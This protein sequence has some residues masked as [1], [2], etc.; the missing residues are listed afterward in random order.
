MGEEREKDV[1]E[2]DAPGREK[3]KKRA[4]V[5]ASRRD[6]TTQPQYRGIY[7]RKAKWRDKTR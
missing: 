7:C 5:H 3:N 6:G 1:K 2:G 4:I